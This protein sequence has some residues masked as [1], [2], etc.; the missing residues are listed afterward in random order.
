MMV[1]PTMWYPTTK[2][3]LFNNDKSDRSFEDI[4][5]QDHMCIAENVY[6]WCMWGLRNAQRFPFDEI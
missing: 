3:I 4:L 6:G 1:N 5:N 2:V